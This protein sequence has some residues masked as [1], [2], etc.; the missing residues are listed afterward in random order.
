MTEPT[1]E[2]VLDIAL[3]NRARLD[4]TAEAAL[5]AFDLN[6]GLAPGTISTVSK[7]PLAWSDALNIAARAH[8]QSMISN[9]YFA[10]TDPTTGSTPQSR[11]GAAGYVG[12][13]GENIAARGST[14]ALT[15]AQALPVEHADL[16][17]DNGVAGRGHRLNMLTDSYQQIGTGIAGGVT[18]NVFGQTLNTV[19]LTE[20][21]GVPTSPGQFLTGIAYNDSDANAFYS[22]GEG[23]AAISIAT[24]GG[25][26]A[27]GTAGAFSGAIGAGLQSLTFSG[28]DLV[29]SVTLVATIVSG[30]NALINLIG[31]STIETSTSIAETS[32]ITQII[33]LGTI[34]LMLA[35]GGGDDTI[36]GTKGDD[37]LIGG[38]GNDLLVGGG[39]FD[40]ANHSGTR[41]NYTIQRNVDGSIT[42]TDARV[43]SPDGADTVAHVEKLQFS[44]GVMHT[45][46]PRDF[47]GEL[48]T[49]LLLHNSNNHAAAV[50]LM[51]G[52]QV[53]S[54]PIIGTQAAGWNITH[55][56]DFNGDGK[57]DLLLQ[58]LSTQQAS[59]WLMDGTTV[60]S[61]P[62]IGTEAPGWGVVHVSDFNGDAKSDLLLQNG[63]TLAMWLMDGTTVL[64]NPV[65]GTI[66]PGWN[67][68]QYGDFNGDGKTDLLLENPTSKQVSIW[69]MDG[70]TVTSSPVIGTEAL[71]W[72]IVHTAD[73]NGDNKSDLL[74]QNGNT[75]ALWLMNGTTVTAN[76]VI[77][78]IAPG[79]NLTHYGDFNGDGKT[80][81][82]LENPTTLQ[83]AFWLM[84]GTTV[85]SSPVIGTEAPGWGIVDVTDLNA[86]G[87]SDLLLENNNHDL[88]VWLMD[89]TTVTAN[90]VIG[91][92]ASGWDF[93]GV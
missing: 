79:W 18:H 23:R 84:N 35:G 62:V 28:G 64:A 2:E 70:T 65:I 61:S 77:G 68:T 25:N 93:L 33:G 55:T 1:A 91:H 24:S 88:A 11:V 49:D 30:R 63:N 29:A 44:D 72:G 9:D 22:I 76:P 46:A 83:A 87:K 67:L 38:I 39:G 92:I 90:P 41:S 81:L 73:F 60:T 37:V 89:G 12:S 4:P 5:F 71:G 69:Q 51:K 85:M 47:S 80:D 40:T 74:L 54:N 45:V 53:L 10:H 31:Q 50:W 32:G 21:Y 66:A 15:P 48:T 52:T 58:N 27:T 7:Q 57:A 82:L 26:L 20:D 43:G 14:S 34:G 3:I 19:M 8:S 78:T 36:I 42:I 16:F 86:D 13:A 6:E 56:A 59:V 75:L 17:V